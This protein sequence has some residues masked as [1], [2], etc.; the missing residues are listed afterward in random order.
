M[1]MIENKNEGCIIC[2][3]PIQNTAAE[4]QYFGKN[5]GKSHLACLDGN[6]LFTMNRNCKD[7]A[8]G[9]ILQKYQ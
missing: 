6:S 4:L 5:N 2:R 8:T 1:K 7:E 3:G 9:R